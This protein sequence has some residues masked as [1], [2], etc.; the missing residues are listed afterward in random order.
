[1]S[2]TD[3]HDHVSWVVHE[4]G[5]VEQNHMDLPCDRVST[6]QS[7]DGGHCLDC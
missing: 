4:F 5:H 7:F 2:C 6:G 3:I 1:M